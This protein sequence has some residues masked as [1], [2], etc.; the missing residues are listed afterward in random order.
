MINKKYNTKDREARSN[1]NICCRHL[2]D[3]AN[4]GAR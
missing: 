1:Y 2:I 4:K 3:Y